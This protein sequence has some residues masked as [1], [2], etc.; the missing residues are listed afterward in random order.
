ML[1]VVTG[2]ILTLLF[3]SLF[4]LIRQA[5]QGIDRRRAYRMRL[6]PERGRSSGIP[7]GQ[8]G[9]IRLHLTRLLAASG[10]RWA[11]EQLVALMAA[12]GLSGTAAG[13][14]LL[15]TVKAAITVG[16]IAGGAPLMRLYS[17]LVSSRMQSRLDFLPAVEVLYQQYVAFGERG[18]LRTT[19]QSVV[20]SG[21]LPGSLKLEFERLS[22]CLTLGHEPEAGLDAFRWS[23][24]HRWAAIFISLVRADLFEGIHIGA[25]LRELIGDMR[26][27]QLE[28][29]QERSKLIEIRVASFTPI[30]FLVLFLG[31]NIRLNPEAAYRFYVLEP[32]GRNMLADSLL[33]IFGSF[34][35]GL[36]LSMRRM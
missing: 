27:A 22:R 28:D 12:L 5:V 7:S 16:A 31:V 30:L 9:G 26:K 23:L 32:M 2:A 20:Q 34:M 21:R 13:G 4:S 35:L 6:Y 14:I 10:S 24:G 25:P 8:M 33:L 3:L 11:P 29:R 18:N 19:L 36:Y 17:R 1:K 15:G